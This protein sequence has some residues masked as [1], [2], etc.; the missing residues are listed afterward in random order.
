MTQANTTALNSFAVNSASG[1]IGVA[2]LSHEPA[3]ASFYREADAEAE[4]GSP[5][6]AK[7]SVGARADT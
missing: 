2:R 4:E 7:C 1:G 3:L 6:H 5:D